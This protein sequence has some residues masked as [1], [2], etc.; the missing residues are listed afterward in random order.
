MNAQAWLDR[1]NAIAPALADAAVRGAV[2]LLLA[3]GITYALRRRTAA[4][5]HLVDALRDGV[6]SG[7]PLP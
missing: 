1:L 4:A 7:P 6:L 2:V 3:L 5:R